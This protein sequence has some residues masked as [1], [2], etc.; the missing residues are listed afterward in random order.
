MT[1][2]EGAVG[3]GCGTSWRPSCPRDCAVPRQARGPAWGW[4][5]GLPAGCPPSRRA[6]HQHAH[7]GPSR[8]PR[9]R[10]GVSRRDPRSAVC[11]RA[12]QFVIFQCGRRA[13][14]H[15]LGD[16]YEAKPSAPRGPRSAPRAGGTRVRLSS[17]EWVSWSHPQ[18][19][20][21]TALTLSVFQ[22]RFGFTDAS[23]CKD[24]ARRDCR[25]G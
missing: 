22:R 2:R 11:T 21:K 7:W 6:G 12:L 19:F 4:Q 18:G 14:R 20:A 5:W 13:G 23:S 17:W 25:R 10:S 1:S 3:R 16:T 9:T 24:D 8:G 15:L